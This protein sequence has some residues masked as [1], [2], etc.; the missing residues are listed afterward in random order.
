MVLCRV[1]LNSSMHLQSR[2]SIFYH[3]DVELQN[4]R[5]PMFPSGS[6]GVE[7]WYL[8]FLSG[9]CQCSTNG[10]T[11]AN[12]IGIRPWSEFSSNCVVC[13]AVEAPTKL[14]NVWR[15]GRKIQ[16]IIVCKVHMYLNSLRPEPHK[17][18]CDLWTSVTGTGQPLT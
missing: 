13:L 14:I 12:G 10:N 1:R 17:I 16:R 2:K 11:G 15:P 8:A 6:K 5:Y 7:P 4:S 18:C 3:Q 9:R